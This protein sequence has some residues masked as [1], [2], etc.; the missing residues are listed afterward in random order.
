MI[1]SGLTGKSRDAYVSEVPAYIKGGVNSVGGA[2]SGFLKAFRGETQL[3]RPDVDRIPTGVAALKP[4]QAIPRLLEASDVFFRTITTAA[5][6]ESLLVRAMKQGKQLDDKLMM[7]INEEAAK[8]GE[9]Y[10]FRKA[11]DPTNKE[12]QG[13]LLSA[14][15]KFT[16]AVYTLRKV[17]G[18]K[19][20]IPFVQTPMN[21]L[22]MGIEYSPLGVAT[23]PGATN[24]AEQIARSLVGS[25]VFAGAGVMALQ[26]NTTW[27]APRNDKERAAFYA[28]GRKPYSIKIGD[29]WVSYSKLG[30]LAYPMAIASA[31]AWY[32]KENPQ[33]ATDANE[34]K[35]LNVLSGVGQF[36]ADQS[37][38]Q[39]MGDLLETL[40]GDPVALKRMASNIPS[41]LIPLVSLQRWVAQIIDPVYRE[42]GKDFSVKSV[43]QNIKKGIPGLSKSVPAEL[44]PSGKPSKV[45]NPLIK[46]FSPLDI[47]TEVPRYEKQ[48]QLIRRQQ[49]LNAIKKDAKGKRTIKTNF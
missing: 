14:I 30:P 42:S 33:A 44:D 17:P 20:F 10:V 31:V 25:T 21:I 49:R 13:H 48:L 41:Q 2:V 45:Q 11:L 35:L 16:S 1:G 4:F 46:A 27:S 39:G 29:N 47:G 6:K 5:E 38:V 34:K 18:V 23:L 8:K 26:G 32:T 43:I 22:K 12:G 7:E 9:E 19:W 36:F 15:D 24:K 3:Y 37:Y 40:S 28:S